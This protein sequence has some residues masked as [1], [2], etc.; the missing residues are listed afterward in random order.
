[1]T[2]TYDLSILGSSSLMQARL[3]IN[4]TDANDQK[5]QDEEINQLASVEQNFWGTC[6]RCC[7][8]IARGLLM[9][10]DVRLGRNLYLIQTKSAAQYEE[11]ARRLRVKALGTHVPWVGGMDVTDKETY[12]DDDSIVQPAF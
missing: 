6:A 8:V 12:A 1:M 2:W 5:L 10:A 9:K 11:M 7:E 4:D 3:E